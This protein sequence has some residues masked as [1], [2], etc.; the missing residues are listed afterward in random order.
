VETERA[1][2]T[3]NGL[4]FNGD[5]AANNALSDYEQGTWTPTL[6]GTWSTNPTSLA[7]LYTKIGNMVYIRL[8]F[9]G[10]VK[11]SN[12]TGWFDGLPFSGAAGGGGTISNVN[13][14]DKGIVLLDNSTRV[15]TTVNDFGVVATKAMASYRV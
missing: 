10:G 14:E 2:F 4:T 1:R 15:W 3:A 5:T 12:T 13:V 9:T 11:A 6:G 7:G 8:D